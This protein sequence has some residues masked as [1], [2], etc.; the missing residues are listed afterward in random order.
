MDRSELSGFID[1]D[2]PPRPE[3]V[4]DFLDEEKAEA[5]REKKRLLFRKDSSELLKSLL[6]DFDGHENGRKNCK[7]L[8]SMK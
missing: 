5:S 7:V 4:D 6:E 1:I 8:T 3:P 2:L